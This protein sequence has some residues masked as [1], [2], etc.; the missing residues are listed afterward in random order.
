MRF[1]TFERIVTFL[2]CNVDCNR[3]C[4]N[5]FRF[6]FRFNVVKTYSKVKYLNCEG[7]SSIR[8]PQMMGKPIE[9]R[10]NQRVSKIQVN[11]NEP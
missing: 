11:R 7:Y 9:R 8:R 5:L 10:A 3:V 2:L 6:Y 4:C 1:V